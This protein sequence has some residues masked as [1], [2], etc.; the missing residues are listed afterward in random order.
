MKKFL[1]LTISLLSLNTLSAQNS[2]IGLNIGGAVYSGDIEV[3]ASN[4][5]PQ[6]RSNIGMF[7][8][9]PL[10]STFNIRGQAYYGQF[11]ANE[12]K[13]PTTDYRAS[14]GL[15][16][17]TTYTEIT[18]RVEWNFLNTDGR[19]YLEDQ[20]PTIRLYSFAGFGATFFKP[21]TNYNTSFNPIADK[22]ALDRDANYSKT[23]PVISGG[24]GGKYNLTDKISV[25]LE[26]SIQKPFTDY[27]DGVSQISTGKTKDY[28]FFAHALVAYSFGDGSLRGSGY[29]SKGRRRNTGCPTF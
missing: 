13:Y 28:Y 6:K 16:F 2:E 25:G 21:Q 3:K 23:A 18:A 7:V 22:V 20:D 5:N 29:Y 4:F 10:N 19:F 14:R 26:T 12:K 17:N 24:L 11:Y 9:V 15:S 1:L 27:I 8:R